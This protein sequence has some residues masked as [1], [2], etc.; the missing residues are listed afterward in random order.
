MEGDRV[1][2]GIT[3]DEETAEGAIHWCAVVH[4]LVADLQSSRLRMIP[5]RMQNAWKNAAA[6]QQSRSA[7]TS[8]RPD[9]SAGHSRQVKLQPTRSATP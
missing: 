2:I 3:G 4:A 9:E 6:I 7:P 5:I 1:A 8:L